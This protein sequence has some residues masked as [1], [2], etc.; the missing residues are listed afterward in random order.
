MLISL[1]SLLKTIKISSVILFFVAFGVHAERAVHIK[2][3]YVRAT[4]PMAES[5]AIYFTFHNMTDEPVTITRASVDGDI[6]QEAQ[7]HTTEMKSDMMRMR[8]V[9][10]GV[11]VAPQKSFAFEPGGYHVMLL[12]LKQGLSEGQSITLSL[13]FDKG[14]ALKVTLPVQK[15]GDNSHHHHHH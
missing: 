10:E 2:E 1:K 12:G 13:Y 11:T 14:D 5:A 8:E 3:G 9:T 4:F 7:I 15:N 6:A